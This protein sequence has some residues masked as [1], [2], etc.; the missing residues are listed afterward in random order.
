M[1][2]RRGDLL[3]IALVMVCAALLAI[4]LAAGGGERVTLEVYQDGALIETVSLERDTEF[5]VEGAYRNTVRVSGGKVSICDSDC[6]TQDCVR[7]GAISR[8]GRVLVCL[9]NRLELRLVGGG[10]DVDL[11]VG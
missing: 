2:F 9:P 10:Q 3:A 1:S 11:V 5:T 8:P 4:R 7:S 6:P